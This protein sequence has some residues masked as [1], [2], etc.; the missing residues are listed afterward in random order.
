MGNSALEEL[1]YSGG[2]CFWGKD[3]YD[4][5]LGHTKFEML[6]RNWSGGDK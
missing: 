6:V 3:G 5:I 2:K 4:L 1:E